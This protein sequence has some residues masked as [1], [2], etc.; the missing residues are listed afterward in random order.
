MVAAGS[1]QLH[2]FNSPEWSNMF[3]SSTF[4]YPYVEEDLAELDGSDN[5]P[6][7]VSGCQSC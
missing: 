1:D 4:Q 7:S 2:D 6:R 3:E 5:L